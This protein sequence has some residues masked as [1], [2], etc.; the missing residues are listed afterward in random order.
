MTL[1]VFSYLLASGNQDYG[2]PD[3]QYA[4]DITKLEN[5]AVRDIFEKLVRMNNINDS[6]IMKQLLMN[7]L[8]A[9]GVIQP[10]RAICIDGILEDLGKEDPTA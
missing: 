4:I 7:T 5:A 1:D 3:H 8:I 6:G 9:R 2:L 10:M